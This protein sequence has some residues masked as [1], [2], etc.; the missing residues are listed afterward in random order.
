[1]PKVKEKI[2]IALIEDDPY[3]SSMYATKFELEGY[4]VVTA[5]DGEKGLA[6]IQSKI[7]NLILLDVMMPKMNGFDVLERIKKDDK[8]K[9]IPVIL[10]TNLN[11]SDEVERGMRMGAVDYLIKAHFLPSEV[12]EKVKMALDT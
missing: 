11:Q 9:D 5:S 1:M 6:L 2:K 3:L 7:P 8:T 12:V 10:L 4:E